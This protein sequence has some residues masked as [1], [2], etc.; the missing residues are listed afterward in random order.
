LGILDDFYAISDGYSVTRAKTAIDGFHYVAAEIGVAPEYCE[1]IE[2]SV[3][4]VH[5]AIAGNVLGIGNGLEE[6]V[7]Q[8]H[9]GYAS[10]AEVDLEEILVDVADD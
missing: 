3:S 6:R 10:T 5:A 2:D 7:G 8:A 4:G 1:F 9:L